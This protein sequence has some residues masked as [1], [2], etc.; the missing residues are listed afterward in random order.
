MC[1]LVVVVDV[2][3]CEGEYSDE[4]DDDSGVDTHGFPCLFIVYVLSCPG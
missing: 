1:F 4:N 3:A 2:E